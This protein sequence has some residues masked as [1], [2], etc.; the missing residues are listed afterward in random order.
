MNKSIADCRFPIGNW[1]SEIGNRVMRK[2]ALAT[3]PT[4]RPEHE[5]L[6]CC[7]RTNSTPENVA[8]LRQLASTTVDWQYFFL[9][10]RRHSVVPL[11]FGQLQQ[12]A[13]DIVP[14]D[15]IRHLKLHYLENSAR[16]TVLTSELCRL[17]KRLEESGIDAI[18]YKGPVLALV[19][20]DNLALRRFVDLDIM[21]R[22]EDVMA[23]RD[24][25]LA[26]GLEFA[27]PLTPAQQEV[28]LKTQHNMQFTSDN[29]LLIVELHWEVA[30]HLFASSVQADDLWSSLSTV[31]LDGTVV[32]TLSVDDLTFSLCVHGS[33]HLWER[34]GWICDIA[35]LIS[36]HSLNWHNLLARAART[37]SER[38]FLLGVCL[39]E[40]LLDAQLP[41]EIQNV[42]DGDDKLQSL[43]QTIISQLFNGTEHVPATTREIFK[44]NIGVRKSL[45]S[46]ARYVLYML[47][48]TDS[49][50]EHHDLP[51]SLSFGY[52]LMR[53]VRLFMKERKQ[54]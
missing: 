14:A 1:Q 47:R 36:R 37:D 26:E 30:S 34:L 19:A 11:I 6:L 27:R 29:R 17:L 2:S 3:K 4:D 41:G 50:L 20:Y 40:R 43:A 39:A 12:H 10:A 23:A 32:K 45:S 9:I 28:L 7:A 35:E 24:V 33:R 16:N 42:C 25:F 48:P 44:Y 53:P 38:M 54:L 8:R 31:D 13:S 51:R 21:V 22:R 49:D 18:P 52:Y 15:T 5:L 46:R